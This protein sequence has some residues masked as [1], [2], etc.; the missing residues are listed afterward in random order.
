[1][2]VLAERAEGQLVRDRD[3]G[4]ARAGIEAGLHRGRVARRGPWLAS[5]SGLPPPV[6]M[7]ATSNMSLTAKL[8]PLKAPAALGATSTRRRSA[9]SSSA[10]FLLVTSLPCGGPSPDLKPVRASAPSLPQDRQRSSSA[11]PV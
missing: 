8:R 3:P 5:Q 1:M 11:A 10:A 7:P 6:T 9:P 2:H 4:E